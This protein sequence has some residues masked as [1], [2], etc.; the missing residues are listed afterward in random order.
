MKIIERFGILFLLAIFLITLVV[1]D[2]NK[3]SFAENPQLSTV[4]FYVQWYDV[5]EAALEG[6]KGI[7][8][9]DKGFHNL[10]EINTVYYEASIIS[11]EKMVEALKKTGTYLGIAKEVDTW[12]ERKNWN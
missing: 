9:I 3:S 8:R 7:K 4:T 2:G 11:I 12:T 6:L 5:G 10:K 1:V